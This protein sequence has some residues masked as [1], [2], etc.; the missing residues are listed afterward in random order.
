ML[1]IYTTH[2]TNHCRHPA[3][4]S[5]R[6]IGVDGIQDPVW[7][8]PSRIPSGLKALTEAGMTMARYQMWA[9]TSIREENS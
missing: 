5:L 6:L 1:F 8:D 4:V 7:L 9:L 3:L 2:I